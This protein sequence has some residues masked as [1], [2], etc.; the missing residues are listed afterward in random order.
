M[1]QAANEQLKNMAGQE[2]W[3][4]AIELLGG[5]RPPQ[6]AD[7]VM[8]LPYEQQ[9]ALFGRLPVRL[10]A[11]LA[12]HFPYFHTYVL[13][14]TLSAAEIATIVDA[15][16]PA[17]RD[18]FLDAL[19]EETWQSLMDTLEKVRERQALPGAARPAAGE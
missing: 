12:G 10:A 14:H 16:Q 8:A 2:R 17:E 15:M 9:Q 1:A 11:S 6:A 3:D 19:P 4:A 7:A 5:L 13:L 18:L